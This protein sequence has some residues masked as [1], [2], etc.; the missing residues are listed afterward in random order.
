MSCVRVSIPLPT[1]PPRTG[2]RRPAGLSAERF[3]REISLAARPQRP[4]IVPLLSAGEAAGVPYFTMPDIE[5]ESLRARLDR[6]GE[7]PVN[8]AVRLLRETASALAYAHALGLVRRDI[9]PDN[10]LVSGDSAMV[11]DFGVAKAIDLA[12]TEGNHSS[13]LASLGVALGTPAWAGV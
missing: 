12:A 11:T 4:H 13:G 2:F 7:L 1:E 6:D 8:A 9:K 5:G 10:V 3:Q